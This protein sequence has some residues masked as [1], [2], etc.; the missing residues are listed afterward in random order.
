V[1]YFGQTA[2]RYYNVKIGLDMA[3]RSLLGSTAWHALIRR[4]YRQ[5]R[6]F[7]ISLLPAVASCF[8]AVPEIGYIDWRVICCL[9]NISIIFLAL[10]ELQVLVRVS[11]N[12]FQRCHSLSSSFIFYSDSIVSVF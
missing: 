4:I 1:K 8:I 7:S 11:V 2:G 9:F 12:I 3:V 6:L 5:D 10:N